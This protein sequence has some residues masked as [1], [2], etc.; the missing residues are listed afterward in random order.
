MKTPKLEE[1]LGEFLEKKLSE[2]ENHLLTSSEMKLILETF[3]FID[4]NLEGKE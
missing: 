4:D 2:K 3:N 1:V